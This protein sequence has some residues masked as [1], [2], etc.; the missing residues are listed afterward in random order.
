MDPEQ[1]VAKITPQHDADHVDGVDRISALPDEI[2]LHILSFLGSKKTGKTSVL[3]TRWRF[4]FA[5]TPDIDLDLSFDSQSLDPSQNNGIVID[6][7]PYE[8]LYA[9]MNF[10]YRLVMLRNGA[11]IRK[12]KLSLHQ[13]PRAYQAA[14]QSLI[15]A[16]L[17][18]K[19]Q[20]LEISVDSNALSR[21]HSIEQVSVAGMLSCKTLVSLELDCWPGG[22]LNV[23]PDSVW[24]PNLKSL[25]LSALI[26]VD[27][28]SIQWLIQGCPVLQELDLSLAGFSH[29]TTGQQQRGIII[30]SSSLIKLKLD[31]WAS[32]CSVLVEC[33][34]LESFGYSDICAR[35]R[36]II[37]VAP[38]LKYL[39]YTV[40]RLGESFIQIP[41]CL[42]GAKIRICHWGEQDS[43]QDIYEHLHRVG[44]VKSL[45]LEQ[46]ILKALHYC[47]R[48]FPIFKNLTRLEVRSLSCWKMLPSLFGCSPSLQELVLGEV[49]WDGNLQEFEC[50]LQQVILVCFIQHL[51]EIEIRR[52]CK[53]EYEFKLVEYFLR[54]AKALQKVTL[55]MG[56]L[57]I[58]ERILSLKRYSKH[59]H[60]KGRGV[61]IYY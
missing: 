30:S 16:A 1:K 48:P 22:N 40:D 61:V 46:N 47:E 17:L 58:P 59:C 41:N 31:C 29:S 50:L 35:K 10:G 36:K 21:A 53:E 11:P 26:L 6:H 18:C 14:I 15:S 43:I 45:S 4:L 33:K 9:F 24:L 42:V 60:V 13:V 19:V 23:P 38:N 44:W 3:S 32:E 52:F 12:F 34:I 54:N 39:A 5:S 25:H 37:L 56:T 20:E 51:K 49:A 27:E 7:P 2:L 8:R 28:D 55:G 57:N